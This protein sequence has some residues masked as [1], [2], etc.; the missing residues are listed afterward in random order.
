ME[1]TRYWTW[2]RRNFGVSR[3]QSAASFHGSSWEE[4][5][6]A[7]D[8]SGL[9]G[10]CIWPPRSYSCTFCRREFRSAQALGG[11]MNVH[12]RDRARLRR[13]PSLQNE[14]SHNPCGFLDLHQY[15]PEVCS[16]VYPNP[17]PNPNP[18]PSVVPSPKASAPTTS[19]CNESND[20]FCEQT[21]TLSCQKPSLF[22]SSTKA[23]NPFT[24]QI[25][26]VPV[27]A[28]SKGDFNCD[29]P[30]QEDKNGSSDSFSR[31]RK[32]DLEALDSDDEGAVSRKKART[33]TTSTL[34]LFIRQSTV[35]SEALIGQHCLQ[36]EVLGRTQ[37]I[38]EELDLELRLGQRPKVK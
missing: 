24:V 37:S 12:R 17:N 16:L 8:C 22:P 27:D 28:K 6:F 14:G 18:N 32:L 26:S 7:E 2:S 19:C 5:A 34:P 4:Q 31:C 36:T 10:G 29:A 15:Q 1:G 25:V 33:S 38:I 13:S 3:D 20:N 35:S 23:S 9:L 11:H 21:L 30:R